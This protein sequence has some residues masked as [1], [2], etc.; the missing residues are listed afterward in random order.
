MKNG[1][2]VRNNV[3]VVSSSDDESLQPLS[4]NEMDNNDI[5]NNATVVLISPNYIVYFI[6]LY[7]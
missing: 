1:V 7:L 5:K 4:P 3:V 6:V 2:V